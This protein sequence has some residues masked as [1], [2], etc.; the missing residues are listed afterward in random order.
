VYADGRQN[1]P[2]EDSSMDIDSSDKDA[3][4]EAVIADE[5]RKKITAWTAKAVAAGIDRDW[6]NAWLRTLGAEQVTGS[7]TYRM[8]VPITG[9]FGKTV[10]ASTRAE[11][12]EKFLE[13]VQRIAA[14]GQITDHGHCDNVYEV[15]FHQDPPVTAADITFYAGPED[16]EPN[17]EPVPDL[18][19]FKDA[20]R[21]MLI[22]GVSAQGWSYLYA[23]K[24][25][26]DLGLEEL[27]AL[28]Y[29]TLQVPVSGTYQVQVR[30]FEGSD[31]AV[32]QRAAASQ[33]RR[34]GAV[35]IKPE[36]MGDAVAAPADQDEDSVSF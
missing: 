5:L 20:A 3:Y 7:S 36:E 6:A 4:T 15:K 35:V 32:V 2:E 9:V 12:A 14:A 19:A 28:Q 8:N 24:A 11:A 30:V 29:R 10:E 17:T 26:T 27:P 22:E 23:K 18:G 33:V 16:P 34:A 13:H 25:V 31:D 21:K 1:Q